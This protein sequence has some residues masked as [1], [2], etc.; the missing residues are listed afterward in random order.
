M[1]F[2]MVVRKCVVVPPNSRGAEVLVSEDTLTSQWTILSSFYQQLLEM[3]T[4]MKSSRAVPSTGSK[5]LQLS[6]IFLLMGFGSLI[7]PV[8][9][10]T[11]RGCH[12]SNNTAVCRPNGVNESLTAVPRG[13]PPTVK[14]IDLAANWIS[15]ILVKDFQNFSVLEELDLKRNRISKIDTGAFTGLVSL[16]KLTLNNNKLVALGDDL[17]AGLSN[18]TELR[19]TSNK[20]KV[21]SPTALKSLRSL[22]FLDISGNKLHSSTKVQYILQQLPNLKSLIIAHN[23]LT[24]FQ[25]WD[26]TNSSLKL[27][28][29]DLSENHIAVFRIVADVFPNLTWLNIGSNFKQKMIWDIRNKTFLSRVSTLDISSLQLASKDWKSFLGDFNSSL[30][31]LRMNAMTSN[32]SELI[33]I[34]C[35]IPTLTTLQL[36]D[37]KLK[38]I[39]SEMFHLCRNVTEIDLSQN[40]L[41]SIPDDTFRSPRY[42]KILTLRRNLLPSVPTAVK[43]LHALLELDLSSNQITKFTCHDFT[44]LTKLRELSL[45][46]NTIPELNDCVFRDLTRLQVLKL[47]SCHITKLNNA[48]KKDLPNLRQLLLNNN[49]I[50]VMKK[51]RFQ[52]LKSLQILKLHDSHIKVLETGCFTGLANLTELQLQSNEIETA[53][54]KR[55]CFDGLTS[56]RRL[57]LGNNHISFKSSSAVPEPLFSQLNLLETLEM[58]AQHH[59][60]RN[61]LPRN[62]LQGLTNLRNFKARNILLLNLH[63]DTFKYTPRLEELDISTNELEDLSA[64][65]FSPL[66]HL[67][68]LYLSRTSLQSLDFLIQANLTKLEFL[69]ARR[70]SFPVIYEEEIKSLPALVY[71]DVSGHG[72]KCDCDNAWFVQWA[73]NNSQTQVFDAYSFKC[74]Y[75]K[76]LNDKKLLDMDVRS[77]SVQTNFICFVCT[78]CS[79]LLLMVASF[80]YH[81]LRWQLVYA[82]YLF[83]A[84]LFDKKQKNRRA[85][86]QYD[87]FISYNAADEPWVVQEMLPKLE[88]EQGWRLCLHHRDFEPGKP[89]MENI[90]DAIYGSRKTICVISRRYLESEWCSREMTLASFRLFDEQKDVLILVFLE[91]IPTAQLSPYYRMRKVL[92]RRTYVSWPRAEGNTEVFWQ[93][94]CQAL[95]TREDHGEDPFLLTVVDQP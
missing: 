18:L 56:L 92:K 35:T 27:S 15:E 81:F 34:S 57:D 72:F 46:Q 74:N 88:D 62:F 86:C 61:R 41:Q 95:K 40:A 31:T 59:K 6:L 8:S 33:S 66:R 69:Q 91:D 63:N 24:H 77:C 85:S 32:L 12:V 16:K 17:F 82:Y 9:G 71:L 20:I 14:G 11:V 29:L 44:N 7:P 49:Q 93:K 89:I 79:T 68:S 51:G 47:Q 21:L 26:L 30:T 36:R 42:L 25:S 38:Q 80:T 43:H 45:Y 13:I 23:E 3:G 22:E 4:L 76:S 67:K 39:S 5:P 84:F 73:E 2:P 60:G 28:L 70:N 75:P 1:V 90:T 83:L 19:I 87:A 58:P 53:K 37:N 65:L 50:S 10:F 52:G 54:L 48:F 64:D 55:G 94:L 78:T